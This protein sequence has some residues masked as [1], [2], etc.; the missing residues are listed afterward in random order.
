MS[1]AE[2]IS[3]TIAPKARLVKAVSELVVSLA[4]EWSF[5]R[6]ISVN[7]FKFESPNALNETQHTICAAT[8]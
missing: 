4:D 5:C 1:G 3:F 7:F 2:D 8:M 6:M